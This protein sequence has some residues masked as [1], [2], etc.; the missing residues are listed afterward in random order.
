[1]AANQAIEY[2]PQC[3][4]LTIESLV[5]HNNHVVINF[6]Y[7][8]SALSYKE[9]YQLYSATEAYYLL[10]GTR[11]D[12]GEIIY[13]DLVTRMTNKSRQK[14]VSYLRFI[15]CALEVL[16][17][18][19]YTQVEN[20][21]SSP[22]ILE[23][24]SE[25][26]NCD[27]NLIQFTGPEALGA[28]TKKRNKPK[29]KK[30]TLEAQVTPPTVPTGNYDKTQSPF[31]EDKQA[32]PKDS[33]E[34]TQTADMGLPSTIPNEGIG[35]TQ[36]LPKGTK[37][38]DKDLETNKPLVDMEPSTT[39][40]TALLGTD[41]K[42]HVDQTKFTR[43]RLTKISNSMQAINLLSFH[44]RITNIENTQVNMQDDIYLIKGM[45]TEM[46]QAFKDN[47]KKQVVVWKKSPSYTKGVPMQ[48][49]TTLKKP[50]DA[51][52]KTAEEEPAR[53][54]RVIPI[55]TVIPISI[56]NH[57]I[58]LI[59]LSSRPLLTNTTLEF[60]VS[61]L[62]TKI[63]RSSSGPVIDITPPEQ[64]KTHLDKEENIKK[65][66]EEAKLLAIRKPELIKV[67]HEEALNIEIDPKVLASEKGGQ[68]FKKI[69]DADLKVRNREHSQKVKRQME[70][71]KKRLEQYMW[72]T[73]SRLKPKLIT[74]V[75]IHP[76]I[77]PAVLT[78]YRG[79]DRRNF[80][81]HNP[82]KFADFGVTELDELGHIIK[83]NKSKIVALSSPTQAQSQSSR[84]KRKHMKLK[85]KINVL[86]WS[87]TEVFL[88]VFLLST[89]WSLKILNSPHSASASPPRKRC[90]VS[91]YS[92]PSSTSPLPSPSARLSRKIWRLL[93]PPSPAT[94]APAPTTVVP[95][96]P[97]DLLP[98][99][100][101]F[102]AE[103]EIVAFATELRDESS[104][105]SL[106]IAKDRVLKLQFYV[107]DKVKR[108]QQGA[109][110]LARWFKKIESVFYISNCTTN[111]QVK[112]AT[113]TL[114]DS[115]LTWWN[116]HVKIVRIDAAYEM[117]WKDLMKMMTKVYCLR[118]EIQTMET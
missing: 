95:S 65:A 80:N 90:R 25:V 28:L 15:S 74:D 34:N 42:Y 68:E 115:E 17:G 88:R 71:K 109:V 100:K 118:S 19:N 86:V 7:P 111:Y 91:S 73:S 45:V 98:P 11:V 107:R 54:S 3:C 18:S 2:A 84:R 6:S 52:T 38:R 50:K 24:E 108:L 49:V 67:I 92:S 83:K 117:S 32:D 103:R 112:Y 76:N 89:T 55:S 12:I 60:P 10:T 4:D 27:S 57:E 93:T 26:S 81:V 72:T 61:K 43:L 13:S 36:P 53:A 21:G 8:Q 14:Y 105:V 16:L 39:P 20:L 82:F 96:L 46:L 59:E 29:S 102:R 48:I 58:R 116:S 62:E 64:P 77:K 33:K 35:K 106:R 101:R 87:V 97:A 9:I 94:P 23:K 22:T 78:I 56:P 31:L 104:R 70:L 110:G 44:Q 30:T 114:L 37:T 113:C 40:V 99:C 1:M 79:N 69:Q 5:F 51:G 66:A 47:L 75:K 41:A 85:P 63:I